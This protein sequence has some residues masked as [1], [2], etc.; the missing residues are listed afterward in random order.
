MTAEGKYCSK[1]KQFKPYEDFSRN[2][3]TKDGHQYQCKACKANTDTK[4]RASTNDLNEQYERALLEVQWYRIKFPQ[5]RHDLIASLGPDP[6][7]DQPAPS[8]GMSH[9]DILAALA[10][11]MPKATD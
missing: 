4:Y 5:A 2:R 10:N 9:E 7:Y 1:C 6:Y 3:T 8:E 11:H